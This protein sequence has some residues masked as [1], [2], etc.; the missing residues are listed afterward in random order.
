MMSYYLDLFRTKSMKGKLVTS[1]PAQS[2]ES[3]VIASQLVSSRQIQHQPDPVA[4]H[5]P[6][7]FLDN[8]HT[9]SG[10]KCKISVQQ[11]FIVHHLSDSD[12]GESCKITGVN[13]QPRISKGEQRNC[14]SCKIT[15]E[16]YQY[17]A[18]Y[19]SSQVSMQLLQKFLY[20]TAAAK[21]A[22]TCGHLRHWPRELFSLTPPPHRWPTPWVVKIQLPVRMS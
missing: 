6:D 21:A 5:S 18:A 12:H 15:S 19:A 13:F 22:T 7:F 11:G 16:S 10:S 20:E 9:A 2:V 17:V 14:Q 4:A 1:C 3:Y 8:C